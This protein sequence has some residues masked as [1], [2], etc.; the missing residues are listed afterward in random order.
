MVRAA[1]RRQRQ[2]RQMRKLR[3]LLPLGLREYDIGRLL[4]S[5]GSRA[6]ASGVLEREAISVEIVHA[7]ICGLARTRT[8]GLL[9]DGAEQLSSM[10][11]RLLHMIVHAAPR[12]A[13]T[14][15]SREDLLEFGALRDAAA[16]PRLVGSCR[17]APAFAL[18]EVSLLPLSAHAVRSLLAE[19]LRA[20]S[21]LDL[22]VARSVH[23][24]CGG[25][26]LFILSL[27]AKLSH[28]LR[29]T[30]LPLTRAAAA[31]SSS[32]SYGASSPGSSSGSS[33]GST[34]LEGLL[35]A[36]LEQKYIPSS[37]SEVVLAQ[38]DRLTMQVHPLRYT[39]QVHALRLKM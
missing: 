12:I 6:V 3:E 10:A 13:I 29:G 26:P 33:P 14:I 30:P 2:A 21:P 36:T 28:D 34:S 24:R 11:W 20:P 27:A 5:E 39:P 9:L 7:L 15:A 18:L 8:Y 37:L 4:G 23:Q 35:V 1:V 17:V 19:A 32:S 25:N 16:A 31:S 38:L 22:D